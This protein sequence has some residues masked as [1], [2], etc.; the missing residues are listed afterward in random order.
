MQPASSASSQA[1]VTDP[2]DGMFFQRIHFD[3]T[4]I[5]TD[6]VALE[7]AIKEVAERFQ[8]LAGTGM[9]FRWAGHLCLSRNGVPAHGEDDAPAPAAPAMPRTWQ[10][11]ASMAV[12]AVMSLR[13]AAWDAAAKSSRAIRA[14]AGVR[15]RRPPP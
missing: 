9:E 5:H 14:N 3:A 13:G 4:E 11:L 2:V 12:W 1:D 7:A 6:R 10:A 15:I 8:M